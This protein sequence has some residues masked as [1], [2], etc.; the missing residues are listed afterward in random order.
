MPLLGLFL[1]GCPKPAAPPT[2]PRTTI[3]DSRPVNSQPGGFLGKSSRP[4]VDANAPADDPL[5][6]LG[7]P[8]DAT[9]SP[10]NQD[11]FLMARPQMTLSYNNTLRFPNWV[12][13]HLKASDIGETERS[14]FV[15]DPDLPSGFEAITT[16][17]YSNSGYDRGHNCPSKDRTASPE[18]NQVVFYMTNITPQQH[19]MNAGPWEGLESYCRTLANS[20]NELYIMCGHGFRDKD[21]KT[22]G[23]DGIAVPDFGWKIVLVLP[24]K[25]GNDLERV[26]AET[27]II[28]IQM[29]NISTISRQP[30][31]KYLT[32][33]T[34]LEKVTGQTFLKGIS[35][36]VA[37]ILKQK[38]DEGANSFAGGSSGFKKSNR[39][40]SGGSFGSDAGGFGAGGRR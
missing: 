29:P 8:D 9:E 16:R 5:T 12:A 22:I 26:T 6:V 19:G 39:R 18:D 15:P 3:T 14:N 27:R 11:H 20:G 4:S 25:S 30:W 34:E 7:N 23:S 17:D 2:Q 35:S 36:S 28:T 32:T 31:D 33:V 38:R 21:F 24:E 1:A 37:Q 10:R 40:S 13:W